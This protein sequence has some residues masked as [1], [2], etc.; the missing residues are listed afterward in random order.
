VIPSTRAAD[1]AVLVVDDDPRNLVVLQ[2]LLGD[3]DL[4]I[5]TAQSG[6]DCL[7]E[8]LQRDFALVLLDVQMPQMDG[9]ET[10]QLIRGRAQT[11]NLPIIFLTAFSHSDA[12]VA[13]AY[14]VRAVDF[15]FKPLQPAALRS[16]V[17]VFVELYRARKEV[18]A[19]ERR[20]HEQSVAELRATLA[21]EGLRTQME[22]ERRASE[23]VSLLA[24]VAT[25]LLGSHDARLLLPQIT[26]RVVD[27]LELDWCAV[28]LVD[29]DPERLGLAA[30]AGSGPSDAFPGELRLADEVQL[31]EA[32]RDCAEIAAFTIAF[33]GVLGVI[34]AARRTDA[35]DASTMQ[36]VADQIALALHRE[37][38]V[39]ELRQQSDALAESHAR[40]DEFLAMLGH[41]LRN[42]LASL[43]YALELGGTPGREGPGVRDVFD[44]QVSHLQRMVDDL[45][46][47][48]RITHGKIELRSGPTSLISVVEQASEQ[49]APLLR[50]HNFERSLPDQELVVDGD[51]V[52]LTQVLTNLLSNAARYTPPG[53]RVRLSAQRDGEHA[54]V[55]VSDDGFGID[56]SV[57]PRVFDL[58]V[59]A[60]SGSRRKHGGLGLGL[61]LVREL[62]AMHG[63]TVTA[64]SAGLGL[65]STFTV[66]LPIL[67]VALRPAPKAVE[68]KT[69]ASA[70][71]IL[72]VE[73]NE[74]ARDMLE[75]Y[76]QCRRHRVA[77]AAD[78]I[79]G[80]A[81]L[82]ELQPTI[83]FV[84]IGLPGLDGHEVARRFRAR[85]PNART[86][87]VALTGFGQPD[88]R[89]A[90][91]EA[92]FDEHLVKPVASS[93]LEHEIGQ[94]AATSNP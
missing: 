50:A 20:A 77:V 40:K 86:R 72:V 46:D 75:A 81:Q 94:A 44:R 71:D 68:I 28:Y 66:R 74:D 29:A 90:A 14:E 23:R 76:L 16:K 13:R 55:T 9:I 73:D 3:L 8:V 78:G 15:L 33:G 22:V 88:D 38:L 62:I 2:A 24:D 4:T 93:R 61:T 34:V 79:A 67:S 43:R 69:N 25:S 57:L 36:F 85:Y 26:E 12:I 10:A 82:G 31:P 52:R 7:R 5:V 89:R 21:A 53:G 63:G 84:D 39:T 11:K 48:A 56:A 45:L 87:L 60:A 83:A 70:V 51:P 65:G 80:L 47:V 91:L 54:L 32:W 49:S 35:D 6:A 58:F 64:T 27:Q 92:G 42:P 37:R 18:E 1:V 30:L 41:E 17:S 19:A 59:Q